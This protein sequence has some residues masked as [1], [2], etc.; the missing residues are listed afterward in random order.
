MSSSIPAK[1]QKVAP[2]PMKYL[3]FPRKRESRE[4]SR[5]RTDSAWIPAC[6]GMT[7][8]WFKTHMR[9][10]RINSIARSKVAPPCTHEILSFPRKLRIQ[11]T[12]A[13]Q[14]GLSLDSRFRGND[15]HWSKRT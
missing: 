9:S 4:P 15:N 5:L 6:A 13:P 8:D 14:D 11:R 3:S 1:A 12:V 10:A 2:V 7:H